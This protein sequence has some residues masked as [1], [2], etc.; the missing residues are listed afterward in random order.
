M[1]KREK[2]TVIHRMS[3]SSDNVLEQEA[4]RLRR[5]RHFREELVLSNPGKYL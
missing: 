1:V 3:I 2:G 4:R 5:R